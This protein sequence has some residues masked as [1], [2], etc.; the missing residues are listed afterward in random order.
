[1]EV[2]DAQPRWAASAQCQTDSSPLVMGH[3]QFS[4]G[5]RTSGVSSEDFHRAMQFSR[6]G[7]VRHGPVTVDR[8]FGSGSTFGRSPHRARRST[9]GICPMGVPSPQFGKESLPNCLRVPKPVTR[10]LCRR[11]GVE[12]R[13]MHL[14]DEPGDT[15]GWGTGTNRNGTSARNLL[16]EIGPTDLD[17][18]RNRHG[19]S[20]DAPRR[21][22]ALGYF[23]RIISV[24]WPDIL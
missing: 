5:S 17:S 12:E 11:R 1:M 16:T 15:E 10:G 24:R 22:A 3:P 18:P 20:H 9:V 19:A 2:V 4:R 23:T 6:V 7:A 21:S 8:D 13:T 14:G